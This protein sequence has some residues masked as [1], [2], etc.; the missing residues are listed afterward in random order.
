MIWLLKICAKIVMARLPV[1]YRAWKSMGIFRHGRMDAAYYSTKIFKLH[2]ERAYPE[3]LP[4]GAVILEIGPG[5]SIASAVIAKA[6]GVARSYLVDVGSFAI[7]DVGFYQMLAVSLKQRGLLSPDLSQATSFEDVL[8]QCNA[9]YMTNGLLSLKSIPS[10]SIDLIWSHSVL[11]HVR[12]HELADVLKELKRIL[13]P[14]GFAS[15]NIDF[16]D[17]LAG[18]LN[19]LRFSESMWES[20]LFSR[21]GFY[22][23]RIP[24]FTM[25]R[26]FRDVGFNI[27]REEF[28]QWPQLPTPRGA[29]HSDFKIYRDDELMNRTSHVLLR[30]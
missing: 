30:L 9:E 3:G 26:M 5:D 10:G 15:H 20:P 28:G 4:C 23:N 22:T 8:Q 27:E 24:A 16:Q 17:H 13:K 29:L 19:N 25:H 7:D 6:H 14:N 2:T 1:S 18:A 12:K 21:S 11:E